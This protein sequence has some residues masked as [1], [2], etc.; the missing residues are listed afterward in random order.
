MIKRTLDPAFINSVVNHPDV[1]PWVSGPIDVGALVRDPANVVLV[2]EHGGFIFHRYEAAVFEVHT[3][4]LPD[5][6]PGHA[7]HAS[8]EARRWMFTRTDVVEAYT[9]VKFDNRRAKHLTEAMN[10]MHRS[11]SNGYHH[12]IMRYE[13]WVLHDDTLAARGLQFH[14][15]ILEAGVG[16]DHS[17]DETHERYVGATWETILGG[18]PVKAIG[19]YNRWAL[20]YGYPPVKVVGQNP[21]VL[22]IQTCRLHI[23]EDDF[24]V[25]KCQ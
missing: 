1:A 25:L 13:D 2:T 8:L 7:W 12:Y 15:A 20:S 19:F 3:Q 5:T 23:R 18:Q 16:E 21:L 22:D 4:F 14:R 6:P 10:W 24:E 9:K 11:D 17:G